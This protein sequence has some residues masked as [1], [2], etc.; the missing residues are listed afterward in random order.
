MTMRRYIE[1]V[2]RL[3]ESMGDS[4][5]PGVKY[6]GQIPAIHYLPVSAIERQEMDFRPEV[7]AVSDEIA[8]T[9][10]YSEPIDVTA[11]RYGKAND[12]TVPV[13]TL[14]DGHHRMAAALQTGRPWLPVTVT[15]INAKGEKLNKLIAMSKEIAAHL[16]KGSSS[17]G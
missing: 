17:D 11:F 1:A 9:M 15:A 2:R 3:H 7:M 16:S 5:Q 4:Y 14:R 10:D 8:R 13:V 6:N 12:D